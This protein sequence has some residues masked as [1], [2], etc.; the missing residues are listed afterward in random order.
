MAVNIL[1]QTYLFGEY[2]IIPDKLPVLV[3]DSNRSGE[4]IHEFCGRAF[5]MLVHFR[6]VPH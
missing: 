3:Y 6:D 2:L 4:R 1:T 5:K